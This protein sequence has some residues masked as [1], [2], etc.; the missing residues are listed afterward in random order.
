MLY[1]Y[2]IVSHD[3]CITKLSVCQGLGKINLSLQRDCSAPWREGL[4]SCIE[5]QKKCA[6]QR[7]TH[8][9]VL[10]RCR[11]A[12]QYMRFND[13]TRIAEKGLTKHIL[14]ESTCRKNQ[15]CRTS[16]PVIQILNYVARLLYHKVFGLSRV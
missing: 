10:P 9:T 7:R 14:S 12:I 11:D 2:E 4:I 3:Y 15:Y 6:L 16:V 1:V 8:P 13:N 5:A